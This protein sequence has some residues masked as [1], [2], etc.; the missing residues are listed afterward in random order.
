MWSVQRMENSVLQ[1]HGMDDFKDI[2]P[3]FFVEYLPEG[4]RK[5]P[6]DVGGLPRICIL[7]YLV[8]V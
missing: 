3:F 8:L 7:L 1:I 2:T 6:K 5:M 4:G